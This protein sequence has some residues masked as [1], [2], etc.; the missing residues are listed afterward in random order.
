VDRPA[1]LEHWRRHHHHRPDE[2]PVLVVAQLLD[3]DGQVLA[4]AWTV[5]LVTDHPDR[6]F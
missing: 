6:V 1:A 2:R 3:D 5:F 4:E